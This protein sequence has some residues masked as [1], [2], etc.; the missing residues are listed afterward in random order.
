MGDVDVILLRTSANINIKEALGNTDL[1]ALFDDEAA[2]ISAL[3]DDCE[4]QSL[5]SSLPGEGS[6]MAYNG[7]R[8]ICRPVTRVVRVMRPLPGFAAATRSQTRAAS[9]PGVDIDADS[10]A[11]P[12]VSAKKQR[13]QLKR[14]RG[15]QSDDELVVESA[16]TVKV[17]HAKVEPLVEHD[18][19]EEADAQIVTTIKKERKSKKAIRRA[20]NDV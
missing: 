4:L 13:R 14:Q 1:N 12:P 18:V 19:D 15:A 16:T 2:T 20:G 3:S 5:N 11:E 8:R 7:S 9:A 10:N 6:V 17:R